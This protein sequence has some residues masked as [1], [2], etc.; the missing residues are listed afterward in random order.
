MDELVLCF[1]STIL[2]ATRH[3]GVF[4]DPALWSQIL[5]AITA[6]P[7]DEAEQ[8]V[9]YKQ[10]VAYVLV[11]SEGRYLS[12]LRTS[13]T[14]EQRLRDLH[15][16]GIGGHVNIGDSSQGVLFG[17]P[18]ANMTTILEAVRREVHEE[19]RLDSPLLGEPE[20]LCFINDDSNEVGRVHFGTVWLI[21]V[22]RPVARLRGERGVG[23]LEFAV[24]TSLHMS[25]QHFEPWSRLLIDY[26]AQ[27]GNDVR[28]NQSRP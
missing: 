6:I 11:E 27:G 25:R 2:D 13:N 14:E 16:I 20:L 15:S 21:R 3:H 9:D 23:R 19:I 8:A 26:L 7:R 28:T 1:P 22:L 10:I 18:H 17:E 4:R 24:L 12:Y 5:A